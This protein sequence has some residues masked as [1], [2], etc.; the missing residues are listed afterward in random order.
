MLH[1][2]HGS[3]RL[4]FVDFDFALH[5]THRILKLPPGPVEGIVDREIRIREP[6]VLRRRVLH[7]DL[8]SIGKNQMDIIDPA[9]IVLNERQATP[10]RLA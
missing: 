2:T 8:A 1:P 4:G 7:G 3:N 9:L 6:L 5:T 10:P